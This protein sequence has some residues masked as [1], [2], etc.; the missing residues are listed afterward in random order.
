MNHF[1]F[2]KS[3]HVPSAIDFRPTK[4]FSNFTAS[5]IAPLIQRTIPVVATHAATPRV[6]NHSLFALILLVNDGSWSQTSFA[7]FPIQS[8]EPLTSLRALVAVSVHLT[9]VDRMS[10]V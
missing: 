5:S 8:N 7:D 9:T 4:A 2:W 6:L 1:A 10:S 3:F